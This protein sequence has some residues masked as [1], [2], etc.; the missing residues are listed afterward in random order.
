MAT[1]DEL[2]GSRFLAAADLKGPVN[3]TI[4][5]VETETFTRPGERDKTKVVV[6]FKGGKKGMVINKTNAANLAASFGK[7]FSN[8][9]GK[10]VTIRPEQTMFG[11]KPTSGLRLYPLN[12]GDRSGYQLSTGPVTPPEPPP[13]EEVPFDDMDDGIR[14]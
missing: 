11:G 12:G 13:H 4:E 5:R 6:Y 8:W 2:Y 1:Y 9:V 7:A 3:A 14:L 10:R